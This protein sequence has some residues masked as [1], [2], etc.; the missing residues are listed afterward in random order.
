MGGIDGDIADDLGDYADGSIRESVNSIVGI[1]HLIAHG[2]SANITCQLHK[3]SAHTHSLRKIRGFLAETGCGSNSLP[4][5]IS[6][7]R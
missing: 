7:T 5:R 4:V 6:H 1:R 3:V 2:R